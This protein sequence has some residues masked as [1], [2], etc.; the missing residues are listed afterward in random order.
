MTEKGKI[1]VQKSK[2]GF[3]GFIE[4]VG[5]TMPLYSYEFK[6]GTLNGRECEVEREQGQIKK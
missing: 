4:I 1:I 3:A 5:K 2:K 6:D